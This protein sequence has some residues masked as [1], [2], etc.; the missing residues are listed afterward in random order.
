MTDEITILG[1]RENS[2]VVAARRPGAAA[3]SALACGDRLVP[4]RRVGGGRISFLAGQN[5]LVELEAATDTVPWRS[6]HTPDGLVL[7]RS[8]NPEWRVR[9]DDPFFLAVPAEVLRTTVRYHDPELGEQI[10]VTPGV[11]YTVTGR[12]AAHRAEAHLRLVVLDAEGVPV[13]EESRPVSSRFRGGT[14]INDYQRLTFRVTMPPE[15]ATA[16]YEIEYAGPVHEETA[17]T[18]TGFVFFMRCALTA[19]GEGTVGMPPAATR[20]LLGDAAAELTYLWAPVDLEVTR[21]E[22][23]LRVVDRDDPGT[24]LAAYPLPDLSGVRAELRGP[25]TNFVRFRVSGYQGQLHLYVDGKLADTKR[26]DTLSTERRVDMIVPDGFHDGVAHAFELRDASGLRVLSAGAEIFPFLSSSWSFVQ[27]HTRS[28]RPYHLAPQ[29]GFRYRTLNEH[30]ARLGESAARGG[31][32]STDIRQLLHVQQV[33][34]DGF[35]RLSDHA[36]LEFP[37]VADP[38]VTVVVPVHNKFNVT[39]YCL[40]ALLFATNEATFDVVV[41]DDGSS[42]ETLRLS[43]VVRGVTVVRNQEAQGFIGACNLGVSHAR[44]DYVVLLN[45]DTEPTLGWLDELLG[46]FDRFDRVG[47]AGSRL[48][49]PDGKLQDGGGIVWGSGDPWNYGREQNAWDPRYTYA[50]QVDYL[51]GAALMIPRSLWQEVGG[52]ST[53]FAPAYFEDTDLAFKVRR[54]GYR[55]WYVPS[56]VVYHFEGISHGTDVTES[57]GLKRFQEVN[58][59]KFKEKWAADFAG[60]GDMERDDPDLVK[61]R[62]IVGR[63]LFIDG[64]TPRPD[65]DAGSYAAI[66]E[67]RLVQSLGYKVTFATVGL[68]HMGRYTEELNR[69][70]VETV[71]KPFY[72]N[73]DDL[74]EKRGS[75]FDAV[76]ITRYYVAAKVIDSIRE[77]APRA[78]VLFNNADLHFLRE[79]RN[80]QQTGDPEDWQVVHE[81]R[82][83]ELGVM[84]EVDLVLSYNE[85]EHAVIRSHNLDETEVATCPWV[86]ETRTPEQVPPFDERSGIAFLGGYRHVPNLQ[87]VEFFVDQVVPRLREQLP[88]V[89]FNIYGSGMP[90]SF[91][92]M[93]DDVINPVGFVETVSEVHDSNRVFVAPLLSG[94]GIKGKVIG[95]MAEGIPTVLSPVAAEGT[96]LRAGHDAIVA[97]TVD[98]WVAAVVHLHTDREAWEKQSQSALDFTWSRF[99][100][101]AGREQMR[102]AFEQVG[103]GSRAE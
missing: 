8:S 24:A 25:G 91:L 19:D 1:T 89:R 30:L 12:F 57:T 74:L 40:A 93:A 17:T 14:R 48:L 35:D 22:R 38:T 45:N 102:Q 62:G 9:G 46:A 87:A 56:S 7:D 82:D 58:R 39:Y 78:K 69:M 4:L 60:N 84:R 26:V 21:T 2:L 5:L 90:D 94:A 43:E 18:S 92:E 75:E 23:E 54:A 52:L 101:A 44:G 51:A 42:D 47:M 31:D 96:G 83:A 20:L 37:E 67:I 80:A 88:G 86:V 95:A 32:V 34:E 63:V 61:D 73:V 41:V 103:L 11:T 16:R 29:A 59:P 79:L 97:R 55:T 100:F 65:Q 13:A 50:R 28:P 53:E 81:M 71:Y 3:R 98:D 49:Y 33:L 72:V 68:G 66:Q 85:V 70:G 15:A 6:T 76:F 36:R 99:S 77:R 27:E 64:Q 10:P